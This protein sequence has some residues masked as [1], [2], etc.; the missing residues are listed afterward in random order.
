MRLKPRK[1]RRQLGIYTDTVHIMISTPYPQSRDIIFHNP[2]TS[3][4]LLA[5]SPVTRDVPRGRP[6]R[7]IR[8]KQGFLYRKG[9]P[10][11]LRKTGLTRTTILLSDRLAEATKKIK[12]RLMVHSNQHFGIISPPTHQ[13]QW[14]TQNSQS[15]WTRA[16]IPGFS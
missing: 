5:S 16:D 12:K 9:F 3:S 15:C 11:K 7:L 8:T 13:S 4:H 10:R 2:R 6:Y 1:H 14:P